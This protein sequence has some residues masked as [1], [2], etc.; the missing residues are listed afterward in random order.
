MHGRTA[1]PRS[2]ANISYTAPNEIWFANVYVKNIE[3]DY[4]KTTVMPLYRMMINEPLM[5]G[6]N[7]TYRW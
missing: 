7:V 2:D 1:L 4:Q 5:Y 6:V 3:D